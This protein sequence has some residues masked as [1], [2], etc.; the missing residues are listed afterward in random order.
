MA[1]RSAKIAK[2]MWTGFGVFMGLVVLLFVLIYNGVIGYTPEIDQLKNPTDKFASTIYAAGGEEMGR[3]YRS[4]GNRVYVDYD[5][6]SPHLRNALVA[7]EDVRFDSHS[8]IDL[9][10]LGR[11]IIKRIIMG[12]TSAGG[13]STITQQLAKQLYSPESNG[14]FEREK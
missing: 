7:T 3:F 11:S 4:K 5:Q 10:A 6:L 14:I 8:G 9:K 13:G 12:N 1:A 2:R